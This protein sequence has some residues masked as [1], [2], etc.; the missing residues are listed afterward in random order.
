M[1]LESFQGELAKWMLRWTKHIFNTAE[2]ITMRLQSMC[3]R[4]MERKLGFLWHILETECEWQDVN[5]TV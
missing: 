4:V 3:S 5:C 2:C 1:K